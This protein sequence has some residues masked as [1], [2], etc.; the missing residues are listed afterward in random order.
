MPGNHPTYLCPLVQ[1][2]STTRSLRSSSQHLLTVPRVSTAAQSRAFHSYAPQLWNRIPQHLRNL[3]F[4]PQLPST[5]S[6]LST[7]VSSTHSS[8][9]STSKSVFKCVLPIDYQINMRILEFYIG[10]RKSSNDCLN[11]LFVR[12]GERELIKLMKKYD[13]T[14][15]TNFS[16]LKC[17]MWTYF[18]DSLEL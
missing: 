13:I 16:Q 5:G 8:N 11:F 14:F 6:S 9:L 4:D 15:E 1:P 3:A 12:S 10:V 7:P 2:Y 17:V 18:V